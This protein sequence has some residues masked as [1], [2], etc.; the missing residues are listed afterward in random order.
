LTRD[1]A[2]RYARRFRRREGLVLVA[3]R[4]DRLRPKAHARE[5]VWLAGRLRVGRVLEHLEEPPCP[6]PPSST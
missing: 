3:C 5:P 4:A 1:A 6:G 2:L